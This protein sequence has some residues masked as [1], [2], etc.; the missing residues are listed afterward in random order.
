MIQNVIRGVRYNVS[1]VSVT[2]SIGKK[3]ERIRASLQGQTWHH[4]HFGQGVP[5]VE[6]GEILR[7]QNGT[8]LIVSNT[9]FPLKKLSTKKYTVLGKYLPSLV[10]GPSGKNQLVK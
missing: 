1:Y 7:A 9:L 10:S 4:F 2:L 5:H 3:E 8:M 6:F